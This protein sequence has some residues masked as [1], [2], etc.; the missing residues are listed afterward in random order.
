MTLFN[1]SD[2]NERTKR[3]MTMTKCWPENRFTSTFPASECARFFESH[4]FKFSI[5]KYKQITLRMDSMMHL[6]TY[7]CKY[8]ASIN[9][10]SLFVVVSLVS[11]GFLQLPDPVVLWSEDCC[12]TSCFGSRSCHFWLDYIHDGTRYRS[13]RSHRK[14]ILHP[15]VSIYTRFLHHLLK[16][17]TLHVRWVVYI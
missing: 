1:L 13:H 5:T 8:C 3:Q 11:G 7:A 15:R 16:L 4:F 6:C 9:L 14:S 17:S 12:P 10:K 2:Y